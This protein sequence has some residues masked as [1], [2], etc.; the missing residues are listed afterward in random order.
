MDGSVGR[1][2]SEAK[3][4]IKASNRV[5]ILGAL[6]AIATATAR[7]YAKEHAA[8]VL[9]GRNEARLSALAADLKARGA[10]SVHVAAM[11]LEAEAVRAGI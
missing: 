2:Q 8:L 1:M 6:S 11:D 5:V 3:Q 9:V 4:I 10:V 7:I